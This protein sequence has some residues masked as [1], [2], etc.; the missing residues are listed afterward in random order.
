MKIIKITKDEIKTQTDA[1][2]WH[3]KN[4]GSITSLE[5]INQYGATRLASIIF[6]LKEN[7]YA[8][9]STDLEFTTRF[10]RKTTISKYLYFKPTPIYEQKMIWG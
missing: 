2:K 10:G 6:N 9:H 1:I 8:I 7:G 3:L 4:Y 5:A